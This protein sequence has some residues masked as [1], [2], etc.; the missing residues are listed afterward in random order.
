MKLQNDVELENTRRKLAALKSLM[1][2]KE[3]SASGSPATDWS[4]E[5]MRRFA[6]QLQ[7]EVEEYER[8]HQTA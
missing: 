7:A 4:L 6:M 3:G 8:A 5:S 1:Q 2:S